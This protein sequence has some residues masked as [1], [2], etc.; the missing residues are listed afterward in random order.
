MTQEKHSCYQ[1]T[2]ISKIEAQLDNKKEKIDDVNKD[3]YH[4]RDQLEGI[5]NSVIELTTIM[6]ENNNRRK[7]A[8]AEITQLKKEVTQLTQTMQTLKWIIG[9]GVPV[10]CTVLTFAIEYLF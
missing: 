9:V 3:Y 7:E 8:D 10:V 5:N 1:E 6:K 4:L 2:R